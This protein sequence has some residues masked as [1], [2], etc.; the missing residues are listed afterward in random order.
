MLRLGPE[1]VLHDQIS[2]ICSEYGADLV[3]EFSGDGAATTAEFEVEAPWILDWR[4]NSEFQRAMAI[5]IHLVDSLTGL[6]RGLILQ[7]KYPGNGVK[8]F[9]QD[10]FINV[11]GGVRVNEPAVDLGIVAAII[12]SRLD[13]QVS[14]DMVLCGEVG[15]TGEVRAVSQFHRNWRECRAKGT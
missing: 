11:A 14:S 7:T 3:R 9:N 15:L 1:L 5:E 4:V 6:H 10:V 12:S 13:Q 8:L 2:G